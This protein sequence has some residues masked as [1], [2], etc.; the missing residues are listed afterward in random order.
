MMVH[1]LPKCGKAWENYID[2]D[3]QDT[4]D[5]NLKFQA[6]RRTLESAEILT[7]GSKESI[8]IRNLYQQQANMLFTPLINDILRSYAQAL[9]TGKGR[10][11]SGSDPHAGNKEFFT[12]DHRNDILDVDNLSQNDGKGEK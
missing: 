6:V 3:P 7:S 4:T 8:H 2:S 9:I 12:P 5:K 10:G 11:E 1:W